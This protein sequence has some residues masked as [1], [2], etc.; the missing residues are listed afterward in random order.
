M[1]EVLALK[2]EI[3]SN[4]GKSESRELRRQ[5]RIPAVI[6]GDKKS[7]T[8]ITLHPVDLDKHYQKEGFFTK[9]L[10]I[11]IDKKNERVLPRDVQIDPVSDR[12]IHVDFMRVTA[13]TR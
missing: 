1:T 13:A 10:D 7:A 5:G 6:Y 3:R 9:L 2:A 8:L 12:V 11:S 4:A